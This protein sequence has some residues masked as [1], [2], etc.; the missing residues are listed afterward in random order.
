MLEFH[1]WTFLLELNRFTKF[2][3]ESGLQKKNKQN[4]YDANGKISATMT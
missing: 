1:V 2:G 3:R 4:E